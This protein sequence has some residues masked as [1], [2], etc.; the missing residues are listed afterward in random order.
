MREG[1]RVVLFFRGCLN[2]AQ[3]VI[4]LF[5]SKVCIEN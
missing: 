1:A 5:E 2:G 4:D 3:I